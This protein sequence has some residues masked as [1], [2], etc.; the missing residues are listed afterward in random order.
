MSAQP[1]LPED[2]RRLQCPSWWLSPECRNLCQVLLHVRHGLGK[3]QLP[4]E[5]CHCIV[6]CLLPRYV[7]VYTR[8]GV[9]SIFSSG[10]LAPRSLLCPRFD[11]D[12]ILRRPDFTVAPSGSSVALAEGGRVQI[13]DLVTTWTRFT[14]HLGDHDIRGVRYMPGEQ[15]IVVHSDNC[16][17]LVDVAEGEVIR[18][19]D[20]NT[21]VLRPNPRAWDFAWSPD[22]RALA[23]LSD[24][25]V[26]VDLD[27]WVVRPVL[28]LHDGKPVRHS[29]ALGGAKLI[30]MLGSGQLAIVDVATQEIQCKVDVSNGQGWDLSCSPRGDTVT[31]G[32]GYG[33]RRVAIVDVSTGALHV[34]DA[35]GDVRTFIYAPNGEDVALV[36][37]TM[38]VSL[39]DVES[40]RVAR[41]LDI[42][43]IADVPHTSKLLDIAYSPCSKF[44]VA[45]IKDYGL[46]IIDI[47]ALTIRVSDPGVPRLGSVVYSPLGETVSYLSDGSLRI[48]DVSAGAVRHVKRIGDGDTGLLEYV[49]DGGTIAVTSWSGVWFVNVDSGRVDHNAGWT[50][51][52]REGGS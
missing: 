21:S 51:Y 38:C 46:F 14:L 44:L 5:V 27:E 47:A 25:V 18:T 16:L 33:D 15:R 49:P 40:G 11:D 30:V 43:S 41:I 29:F 22:S 28:G 32:C 36:Y 52:V 12:V 31:V 37:R 2:C 6:R 19:V 26:F 39:V 9:L 42:A 8:N 7:G 45:S 23:A 34:V 24:R 50:K 35:T 4:R 17:W 10:S 20:L 13:Y 48:V 1:R 3:G